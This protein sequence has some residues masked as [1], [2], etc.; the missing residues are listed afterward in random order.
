MTLEDRFAILEAIA[1]YSYACDSDDADGWASVFTDDGV[2]ESRRRGEPEPR[3][4]LVGRV[5]LCGWINRFS[6]EEGDVSQARH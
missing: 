2:W 6:R 4:R 3:T 5:A 1:T